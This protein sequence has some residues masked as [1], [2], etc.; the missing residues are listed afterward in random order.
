MRLL[1]R[2]VVLRGRVVLLARKG[3]QGRA[4]GDDTTVVELDSRSEAEVPVSLL[5]FD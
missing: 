5:C 2:G 1:G 4:G 3:T